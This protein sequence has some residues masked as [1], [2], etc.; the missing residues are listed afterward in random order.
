MSKKRAGLHFLA[1]IQVYADLKHCIQNYCFIYKISSVS[2]LHNRWLSTA[3]VRETLCI[4]RMGQQTGPVHK[5]PFNH[6]ASL[7]APSLAAAQFSAP[8]LFSCTRRR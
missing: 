2:L 4:G 8:V 5:C 7:L 6:S 3:P 1:A